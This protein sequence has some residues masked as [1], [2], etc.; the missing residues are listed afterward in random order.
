MT[1]LP[2]I[3]A[4]WFAL[5]FALADAATASPPSPTDV[6][7]SFE[8]VALGVEGGIRT[9]NLSAYLLKA[10]GDDRY[11]GLDAGTLVS[12]TQVAL[13]HGALPEAHGSDLAAAGN[14]LRNGIAG[15]FISHAHLD[16]IAG[17]VIAS[18]DDRGSKPLYGLASTTERLSADYFNW[19]AWPNLANIGKA[20][21]LGRYTL[22]AEPP[23]RWFE[24]AGTSMQAA[25]YPLWH[26]SAVSS[27]ILLRH[28][29]AYYAYFGD[30]GPDALSKGQHRLADIWQ[31]LAPLVR[32]HR[33]KGLQIEV[34]SPGD[35]PDAQLFGHMTP[36]WLHRELAA[37]ATQV[38]DPL[39]LHG[40][41][42]I[43][44]HIKP[45]LEPGRDP[46]ALIAR[47]LSEGDTT[48]VRYVVI[49]QGDRVKL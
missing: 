12:G 34:S 3:R 20:P 31:V 27:M 46:R 45:S 13:A 49:G 9:D 14:V 24:V 21:A 1:S 35:V 38:G 22:T 11:L 2:L 47:E 16:H 29:D 33:L 36:A 8:L 17:L 23:G 18:P 48:G 15:Y 26:D 10:T 5:A 39:A 40:L 42:V 28:G 25:I 41:P 30:T 4:A 7:P 44:D 32:A 19:D 37:L 43:I 6:A